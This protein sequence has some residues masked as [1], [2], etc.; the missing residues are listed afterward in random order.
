[1]PR[2]FNGLF[3]NDMRI[4]TPFRRKG[5]GSKVI[6]KMLVEKNIYALD[7]VEDGQYFW[8]KFNFKYN[9]IGKLAVLD[10]R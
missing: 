10:N 3:I 8:K 4:G 1:M 6:D 5:I 9:K 2:K 7:P